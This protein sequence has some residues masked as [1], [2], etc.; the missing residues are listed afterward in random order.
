MVKAKRNLLLIILSVVFALTLIS[1]V[2]AKPVNAEASVITMK[3]TASVRIDPDGKNGIRFTGYVSRDVELDEDT[4]AGII[5]GKGEY[6][7]EDLTVEGDVIDVKAERFDPANSTDAV[8]AFNAVIWDIPQVAYAQ[9]LTAR[10][11]VCDAGVYTYSDSVLTRS[12]AQVASKSI[13]E[14]N[15]VGED[16]TVLNGYVDGANP[17]LTIGDKV[18]SDS[19]DNYIEIP[20]TES[21]TINIEPANISFSAKADVNSNS[22]AVEGNVIKTV[23]ANAAEQ[24]VMIDLGSKFYIVNVTITDWVDTNIK[25]NVLADYDEAGYI[26]T[27]SSPD[28]AKITWLN[29]GQASQAVG[30]ESGALCVTS[31]GYASVTLN[32]N[33]TINVKECGTLYLKVKHNLAEKYNNA[34]STFYIKV[35][36][37]D[38][39]GEQKEIAAL[40][41]NAVDYA[42]TNYKH[43][44][45]TWTY[46][47]FTNIDFTKNANWSEVTKISGLN[48]Y[49]IAPMDLWIDEIGLSKSDENVYADFNEKEDVAGITGGNTTI[50]MPEDAD[51]PVGLGAT[52]GVVKVD[53]FQSTSVWSYAPE[54]V[55]K[56]ENL[57]KII[58][59]IYIPIH[60]THWNKQ[61][62]LHF[63][64]NGDEY[65]KTWERFDRGSFIDVEYDVSET[66][67]ATD[68]IFKIGIE[69]APIYVD[70]VPYY[71]DSISV[72][73]KTAE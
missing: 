10:A 39:N 58:L 20:A 1:F 72:V 53:T 18:L 56:T 17:V 25:E 47:S 3:E 40:Y 19:E 48:F 42:S 73:Y 64:V 14:D 29:A 70:E 33:K 24:L 71:I 62:D 52:S 16:L 21:A 23:G 65:K 36:I 45:N 4:F 49:L 41:S 50:L 28:S 13:V 15:P 31:F 5:V 57:S 2:A 55:L 51:Y 27:A 35:R 68:H 22:I 54:K 8:V 34:T 32:F 9:D 30:A 7:V 38:E 63:Y 46:W 44:V 43:E 66:T 26:Y 59:R 61:V 69:R 12:L 37:I 11:Y 60:P 6:A 67:F